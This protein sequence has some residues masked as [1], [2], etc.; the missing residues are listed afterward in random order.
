M[1][2]ESFERLEQLLAA[3]EP[4]V[5]NMAGRSPQFVRDQ[6]DRVAQYGVNARVSPK[7]LQWLEDLY[8]EHVGPLDGLAGGDEPATRDEVLGDSDDMDDEI[9]F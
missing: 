3:L 8:V 4:E 9:P 7:Q 6:L 2:P 5:K 1:T